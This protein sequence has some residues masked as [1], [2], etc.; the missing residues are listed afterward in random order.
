VDFSIEL[1][2][3]FF[4]IALFYAS[5]GFGGGSSYLAVLS[6]FNID[7]LLLRSTS[8]LCNITVV[9]SGAYVFNKHRLI[10][11]PKII[12]LIICSVPMAYLGG[13]MRITEN[14]FFIVLGFALIIAATFMIWQ[15]ISKNHISKKSF[16]NKIF[17]G[18]IGGVIGSFSGMIGIGGGIFLAPV[19]HFMQW[20]KPKVI[21][22]TASL[23]ILLNSIAGLLGQ[24]ANPNF[25]FNFQF[26]VPLIIAVFIGGQIGTRLNIAHFKPNTIRILTAV[27]IAFVGVR[28]LIKYATFEI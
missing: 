6:L 8:L 28:I 1:S 10:N 25:T 17:N 7:F 9:G 22:A 14:A 4:L 2:L 12:P 16:N 13:R 21:A 20:D 26:A 23:F 11:W 27:L 18:V 19:L 24:F 3:L 5:V 15:A